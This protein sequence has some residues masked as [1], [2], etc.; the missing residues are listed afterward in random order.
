MTDQETSSG[1]L[2]CNDK[3]ATTRFDETRA[4]PLSYGPT[5]W[6]HRDSNPEPVLIRHVVPSAFVACF[7]QKSCFFQKYGV[8][9]I[10]E[11][12]MFGVRPNAHPTYRRIAVL[13]KLM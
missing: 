6:S 10:S 12:F 9:S 8:T 2:V 13:T 1:M 11:E 4:L 5:C 7:F 3:S